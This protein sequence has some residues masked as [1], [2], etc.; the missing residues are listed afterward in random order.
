MSLRDP[1]VRKW[2]GLF[3]NGYLIIL[4]ICGLI[5]GIA[6]SFTPKPDT[7]A[8]S[9]LSFFDGVVAIFNHLRIKN[10]Q[11]VDTS[12]SLLPESG[13][14]IFK[15][16]SRFRRCGY[17]A[18]RVSNRVLMSLHVVLIILSVAGA[19]ELALTYRYTN[20]YDFFPQKCKIF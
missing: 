17:A 10:I 4:T 19:I 16:K 1:P 14:R 9:F 20:P 7:T 12:A 3:A 13:N 8:I 5:D 15:S 18:L 6:F 2:H 11:P